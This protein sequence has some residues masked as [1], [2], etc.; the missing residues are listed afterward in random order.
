V[1]RIHSRRIM[2]MMS[3]TLAITLSSACGPA[4]APYAHSAAALCAGGLRGEPANKRIS[5]TKQI[6]MKSEVACV[7]PR[8]MRSVSLPGGPAW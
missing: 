7:M 3:S 2:Q 6:M 4:K 5:L 8:L 1:E